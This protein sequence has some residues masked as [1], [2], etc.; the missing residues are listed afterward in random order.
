MVS[1]LGNDTKRKIDFQQRFAYGH[2]VNHIGYKWTKK[3]QPSTRR[4]D[5]VIM[6]NPCVAQEF[7]MSVAGSLYVVDGLLKAG[8]SNAR[9]VV[10]PEFTQPVG[11]DQRYRVGI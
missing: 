1:R 8:I 5:A 7:A 4:T 6:T 11:G 3:F 9:K 2:G 10:L